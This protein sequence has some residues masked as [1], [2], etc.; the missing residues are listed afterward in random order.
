MSFIIIQ[1]LEKLN[2]FKKL[3]F[4]TK[5]I[6]TVFMQ[7]KLFNIGFSLYLQNKVMC[8]RA[9]YIFYSLA[10]LLNIKSERDMHFISFMF[11]ASDL[12]SKML[13]K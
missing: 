1:L 4:L 11:Y 8:I 12:V 3:L 5:S 13:K 10:Y 2:A 9:F 6:I 7:H